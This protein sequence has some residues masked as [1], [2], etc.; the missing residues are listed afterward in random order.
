MQESGSP[1]LLCSVKRIMP[2]EIMARSS[3]EVSSSR[4]LLSRDRL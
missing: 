2:T 1:C 4:G 3:S